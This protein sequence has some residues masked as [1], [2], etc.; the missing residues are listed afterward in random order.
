MLYWQRFVTGIPENVKT[1]GIG[2]H[3][4][5][6]DA[7]VDHLDEMAGADGTG[8]DI[9][10]LAPR[11]APVPARR[12]RNV[13]F[14]R[15]QR[16]ED[17]VEPIDHLLVAANH[18]AI[19]TLDAPDAAGSTDIEVMQAA[20]PE[21]LAAAN[22]VL[23]EGVATVDDSVA[24]LHQFCQSLDGRLGDGAGRQHDPGGARLLQS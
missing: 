4:A 16:A 14:S 23:P 13:A 12:V 20:F 22:I 10:A 18:H 17:R 15:S 7:V 19:A 2:L 6:F 11:V 24:R 1:F 3:Q 5:V 21:V 8:V 9:A